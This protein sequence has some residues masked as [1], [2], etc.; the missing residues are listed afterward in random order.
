MSVCLRQSHP[1]RLNKAPCPRSGGIPA[2]PLHSLACFTAPPLAFS[3]SI[4]LSLLPPCLPPCVVCLPAYTH[5]A[6]WY[7]REPHCSAPTRTLPTSHPNQRPI[8]SPTPSPSQPTQTQRLLRCT[9]STCDPLR[10]LIDPPCVTCLPAR[11]HHSHC[12][13]SSG[14]PRCPS[15]KTLITLSRW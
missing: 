2:S 13:H 10:R 15:R 7:T 4:Y 11:H 8:V 5:R 14:S 1:V 9:A 12:N 3:A 6:P